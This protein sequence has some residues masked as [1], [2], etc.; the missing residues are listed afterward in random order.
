M[1]AMEAAGAGIPLRRDKYVQSH[2]R[3]M[4]KVL[5]KL[6]LVLFQHVS[7][8]LKWFL[9]LFVFYLFIYF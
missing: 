4:G 6:T 8:A 2:S 5:H 9:L 7:A 1:I 3:I